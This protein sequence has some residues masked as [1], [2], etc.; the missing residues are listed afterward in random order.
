M[1]ALHVRMT[2]QWLVP[3]GK[4]RSMTG[5]LHLLMTSTRGEPGSVACSVSADLAEK[6][7]IRYTEE[8]QSEDALRRQFRT[9]RF[10]SLVALV[11]N[12]TDPP[13]V[14]FLLPGGSR[15]LDYV[16]DVCSRQL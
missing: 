8:W 13:V 1:T 7:K 11:E 10:K 16:E 2:I 4:A 3:V 12:A 15:G 6:G 9:D 5:A 14:E